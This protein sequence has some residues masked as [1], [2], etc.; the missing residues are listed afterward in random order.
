VLS[1]FRSQ[2]DYISELLEKS[3]PLA[4]FER[5]DILSGT[6]HTFQ[7]EERDIVYLS[8]AVDSESHHAAFRFLEKPDVFN[9]AVTRARVA[10][11]IYTS[12]EPDHLDRE[13]LLSAYLRHVCEAPNKSS[14]SQGDRRKQSQA[15][16]DRF[17]GEVEAE[18]NARGFRTRARY[19]MAGM[20]VDL[21]VS[22][23]GESCGID[24]VGFPGSYESAFPLERYEMFHRAGFRI[25]PIS[26][27]LWR[28]GRER[29]LQEI[30]RVMASSITSH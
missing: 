14:S 1:P 9:V 16:L 11:R 22:R 17:L 28:V 15:D 12:L 18:L 26:Y 13:T 7:G 30:E 10:Q 2:V 20:L 6:A 27:S 29:C 3:L 19:P 8:L 25:L 23:D 21:V 5:H 4:A 24:L